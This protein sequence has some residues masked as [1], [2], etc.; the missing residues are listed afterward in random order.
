MSKIITIRKGLDLPI[1]G[2]AEKRLTDARSIMTYAMKPTDF[3][4]LTPRLLVEEGDMMA[5]GDALFCDK[6]DERIRFTSPVSGQVKAIVRGE[7]RKL[8]EVV[9]EAD[10]KSTGSAGSDYKSSPTTMDADSIKEAKLKCGLWTQLR[11]R[12][13]GTVAN[14]DD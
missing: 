14:P 12:P 8:L 9:V 4:G 3:V 13:F 7:K 2:G 5:V 11:Q 10:C 1:S 6:S